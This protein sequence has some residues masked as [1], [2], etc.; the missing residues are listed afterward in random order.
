MSSKP[1]FPITSSLK[2]KANQKKKRVESI[3]EF[4]QNNPS[5][6]Q[7]QIS[8]TTT[9]T[10]THDHL[11]ETSEKICSAFNLT[12]NNMNLKGKFKMGHQQTKMAT[13]SPTTSTSSIKSFANN[14]R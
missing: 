14:N 9:S 6:K 12:M 4:L 8:A 2:L 11:L 7:P 5:L 13:S 1:T 10:T 3:V